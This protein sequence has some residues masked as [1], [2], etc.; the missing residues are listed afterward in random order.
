V[1]TDR[2]RSTDERVVAG[3]IRV[4]TLEGLVRPR[5]ER[6]TQ[7]ALTKRVTMVTGAAGSGK[8]TMLAMMAAREARSGRAVAWYNAESTDGS[9]R[10]L[11]QH[12]RAAICGPDPTDELAWPSVDVAAHRIEEENRSIILI[13]DDAHELWRTPAEATLQRLVSLVTPEFRLVMG[14][15]TASEMNLTA[16][17]LRDEVM[18]I[19]GEDLRFRPWEVEDLFNRFYQLHLSTQELTELTR[20]TGGWAAGLKLFHLAVRGKAP[21]QRGEMLGSLSRKAVELRRYLADNVFAR[22]DEHIQQFLV[23]TCVLGTLRADWCDEILGTS[24]SEELL[25][26]VYRQNLFLTADPDGKVFRQHEVLRS[27]LEEQLV[28]ELG[29]DAARAEFRRAGLILDN[30]G[31]TADALRAFCRAEDWASADWILTTS[32]DSA[33]EGQHF[34]LALPAALAD[35]DSWMLLAE[36][37]RLAAEF[38]WT[39]ASARYRRAE[40]QASGG[41]V[42]Q[43]ARAERRRL[44]AWTDPGPPIVINWTDA[45]R[46]QLTRGSLGPPEL[47]QIEDKG[48][49]T[50]LLAVAALLAG[51]MSESAA[52]FGDAE[53]ELAGGWLGAWACLGQAVTL[54]IAGTSTDRDAIENALSSIEDRLP[55]RF[56]KLLRMAASGDPGDLSAGA[57]EALASLT[58]A[59]NPWIDCALHGLA[60]IGHLSGGRAVG[61]V[62]SFQRSKSSATRAGAGILRAWAATLAYLAAAASGL[63]EADSLRAEAVAEGRSSLCYGALEVVAAVQ[64]AASE[65]DP[66]KRRTQPRG[67]QPST[68]E[69]LLF[70]RLATRRSGEPLLIDIR[71][72]DLIRLRC[73]GA[74]DMSVGGEQ[75]DTSAAKPKV[76]SLLHLLAANAGSSVHRDTLTAV[77]WPADSAGVATHNLQVTVST[78][79]RLLERQAG[80][81]G[82]ELI[83]R[84]GDSYAIAGPLRADLPVLTQSV[85]LGRAALRDDD[86]EAAMQAFAAATTEYRG[87]LLPEE[88]SA[89]WV[90]EPREHFRRLAVA[91]AHSLS[92]L[93]VQA[94]DYE[95]AIEIA[96]WG[97]NEDRYHDALWRSLIAAHTAAGNAAAARRTQQRYRAVLAEIGIPG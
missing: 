97:L 95:S 82:A 90:V 26:E 23:R 64:R 36:A 14:S 77:L 5:L 29:E 12:L 38:S 3:K 48:Q 70:N 18:E 13:I 69:L 92:E 54:R 15:R 56:G 61:A 73:L 6:L 87:E 50:L 32:G 34:D 75:M 72:D 8:T 16:L 65:L 37:R 76:R 30:A 1:G 46:Y 21:G 53:S 17:R 52:R 89:E 91:A 66:S 68:W 57:D 42:L 9:A 63:S 11:L 88:G 31:V 71:G 2:L 85:Q 19:T 81:P 27:Y 79:R 40:E 45:L 94:Q 20:R 7:Q 83:V 24:G 86:S 78:L 28:T 41:L 62:A 10:S 59:G 80:K 67:A 58:E 22:L 55:P 43:T 25:E 44:L 4:P 93:L 39:A 96:D 84:R 74:F 60:G 51:Q 49:R 33:L 35:H 47:D